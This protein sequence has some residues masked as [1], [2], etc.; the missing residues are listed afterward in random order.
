MKKSILLAVFI[1]IILT[2][3]AQEKFEHPTHN[4][5]RHLVHHKHYSLSFDKPYGM[6]AWVAYE[7]T[8]EEAKGTLE[9]KKVKLVSDPKLP[10][11]TATKKDYKKSNYAPGLLATPFDMAFSEEALSE[12]QYITNACPFKPFFNNGLWYN[13]GELVRYWA[14]E[15]GGVY[16]ITGPVLT[17]APFPT[18]G[19]NKVSVPKTLYKVVMDKDKT[20]AV[21]FIMANRNSVSSL[22]SFA[23]GIDKVEKLTEIDFFSQLDDEK[24]EKLEYTFNKEDWIWEIPEE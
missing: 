3:N 14:Q 7:L 4:K 2:L 9:L 20:K 11:A 16:V 8:A 22:S 5:R 15:Y 13:L 17:E 12:T 23:V 19:K 24:E 10:K 6:P 18:I 1:C 21:G